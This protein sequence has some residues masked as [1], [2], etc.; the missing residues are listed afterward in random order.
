MLGGHYDY[1]EVWLEATGRIRSIDPPS[2]AASSLAELVQKSLGAID[3]SV[4]LRLRDPNRLE[5]LAS[6][7][8]IGD[9]LGQIVSGVA[10]ELVDISEPLSVTDRGSVKGRDK[11]DPAFLRLTKASL[12]VPLL[13]GGRLVGVL[14]VGPDRSGKP[15]SW[16]AR[17]FLQVLAGHAAGELHKTELLLSIV[18]AKEAEAFKTFSTFLLHDLKNFASTLSLIARNAVRHQSN[19]EF[20]RDSFRSVQEIADKMK[21]LCNSL[22]T[23][24][25]GLAADK[26]PQDLNQLIT[27]VT[28]TLD[29]GLADRLRLELSELPRLLADSEE[30]SRVVYNLILNA[31]EAISPEE[32]WIRIRTSRQNG[33]AEITVEDNG[34]G[35]SSDFMANRLFLPFHTTKSDGLGI[36][37]FQ[38]KKIVEAHGGTVQVESEIGRGTLVR[39]LLPLAETR[40]T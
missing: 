37:L 26:A 3:V 27:S 1:R 39:V 25:G 4:W 35:M 28:G 9:G 29:R 13:S 38:C 16:E 22:R 11:I 20:Q 40:L 18:Q 24:S 17:E 36:G 31:H 34:C 6:L 23:F 33:F 19:P 10:E 21:R 14:T 5:L 2:R 15:Y 30:I 8:I 32:G 7:G 12:L